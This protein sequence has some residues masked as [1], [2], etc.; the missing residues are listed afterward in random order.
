MS[1]IIHSI[2]A[3]YMY[4]QMLYEVRQ[5]FVNQ[6][7]DVLNLRMNDDP[8]NRWIFDQLSMPGEHPIIR[9]V[10]SF[11]TS[12]IILNEINNKLPTPL[13]IPWTEREKPGGKTYNILKLY[14]QAA[15]RIVKN[16]SDAA[17]CVKGL[18]KASN[19][20]F[21]RHLVSADVK[22]AIE[23][24]KTECSPFL[25]QHLQPKVKTVMDI[26]YKCL[27]SWMSKIPSSPSKV[28][29]IV[30]LNSVCLRYRSD[31]IFIS[32]YH[33]NKLYDLLTN[34]QMADELIY[35][36]TRRYHTLFGT[37]GANY[38]AAA[39]PSVFRTLQDEFGVTQEC[40]ASP[41]NA[42]FSTFCSAFLDIDQYFG[43]KG[44]FFDFKPVTG[45][46]EVG[47]PYVAEV[48]L[49]T[50]KHLETLLESD[51][52]LSFVLFVPEWRDP[53]AEYHNITD[54][55]KYLR[56]SFVSEGGKHKYLKGDQQYMLYADERTFTI[57][58][59]TVCYILQNEAG[60]KKWPVTKKNIDLLKEA[61]SL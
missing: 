57:P 25:V 56:S 43:S 44:S 20:V 4:G 59:N 5:T 37:S 19:I 21:G 58:F 54:K 10:K 36:C 49:K 24:L 50:V 17:Q 2:E 40:F 45:S 3:E 7:T 61:M 29:V 23:I 46:F 16:R 53:V 33:Y 41:F 51:Q 34:K 35:C 6:C 13:Y 1:V 30:K 22:D 18:N 38:H 8:I 48:M 12:P 15:Q 60:S 11:L 32:D 31:D 52:P 42:Y 14:I 9:D 39:P 55:S 47:P 26:T 28:E 27:E